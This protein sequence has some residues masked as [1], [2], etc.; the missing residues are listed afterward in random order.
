MSRPI[1]PIREWAAVYVTGAL[2]VLGSPAVVS[3]QEACPPRAEQAE[4]TMARFTRLPVVAERPYPPG[5]AVPENYLE[6]LGTVRDRI[7][8]VGLRPEEI[9]P[10]SGREDEIVCRSLRVWLRSWDHV[11]HDKRYSFFEA[12][13][14]YIVLRWLERESGTIR[15]GRYSMLA[16]LDRQYALI[17]RVGL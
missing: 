16:V 7:G 9:R 17:D 3:A 1:E 8:L 12:R 10:L 14:R 5:T 15:V 6:M 13:N 4:R 11:R 2:L